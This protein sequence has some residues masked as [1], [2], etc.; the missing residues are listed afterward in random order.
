MAGRLI[1]I[2]ALVA[3]GVLLKKK[4]GQPQSA[5]S[6][7]TVHDTIEVD[8]PLSTAC[9][10]W[11]QFEEFP[12]FMQDVLEV[13][14]LDDTHLRW[15]AN[16]AGKEEQWDAE[17]TSQIPARRIAWRS[18][19]GAPNSG[20]VGFDRV[21]DTRTRITLQMS[22]EPPGLIEKIGDAFGA[23]KLET[24]SNLRRF[25][26]FIESRQRETGAWRGTVTNGTGTQPRT[27]SGS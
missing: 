6:R 12:K 14:Q 15:R 13:R 18:T 1:A 27:H 25:A 10:Q 9:N 2:A 20:V 26:D 22:Y 19:S 16:I 24:S 8:V 3:A 4:L 7:S 11:T 23:V 21:S 17:I 5:G